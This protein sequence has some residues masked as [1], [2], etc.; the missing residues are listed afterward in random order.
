MIWIL[1]SRCPA[2]CLGGNLVQERGAVAR[3]KRGRGE[4]ALLRLASGGERRACAPELADERALRAL[5]TGH[6]LLFDLVRPRKRGVARRLHGTL[7]RG[8]QPL[9][10]V[11]Q[12][13]IACFHVGAQ[14]VEQADDVRREPFPHETRLEGLTGATV[15]KIGRGE[16][17]ALQHLV[18][19]TLDD[20][21]RP[22]RYSRRLLHAQSLEEWRGVLE[23]FHF[24]RTADG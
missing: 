8:I 17:V 23:G 24:R 21:P 20:H 4:H 1:W 14:L 3:Q 18:D 2:R 9:H 13:A 11:T 22:A 15:R 7:E 10:R 16:R 19:A 6:Q 12:L 5:E